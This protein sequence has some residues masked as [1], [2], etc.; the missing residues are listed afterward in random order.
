MDVAWNGGICER[1][2]DYYRTE[3]SLERAW[4][5]FELRFAE[6][7][8]SGNGSPLVDLR[9]DELVGVIFWPESDFD[10]W[11]DDLRFEP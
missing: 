4:Q 7:K 2:M 8:Q 11:V 9:S 1:C 5:R 6:L 3:V 10:L